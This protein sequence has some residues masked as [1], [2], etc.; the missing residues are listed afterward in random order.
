MKTIFTNIILL[1]LYIT[2]N[3]QTAIKR[4]QIGDQVPD[5]TVTNVVNYQADQVKI[6]DFAGKILILDYWFTGCKPCIASWPKLLDLQAKFADQIQI[7]LVNPM[8]N[9]TAVERFIKNW[10]QRSG[11]AFTLPSVTSD[12]VL[13]R[14]LPPSG[15]PTVVWLDGNGIFKAVTDGI[16]L[17]EDNINAI[18]NNEDIGTKKLVETSSFLDPSMPLY[19]NGNGGSGNTLEW[20]SSISRFDDGIPGYTAL[21]ADSSG[22]YITITHAAIH[23]LIMFAYGQGPYPERAIS[24]YIRLATSRIQYEISNPE[25]VMP[26]VDGFPQTQNIYN[27][28]LLSAQ[29]KTVD[30]LRSM[31]RQDI[32][33]YFDLEL[34]LKRITTEC[35]VLTAE[36]TTLISDFNR[37]RNPRYMTYKPGELVLE[38]VA[39]DD[40]IGYLTEYVGADYNVYPV[41][42]ETGFKGLMDITFDDKEIL[43]DYRKMSEYLYDR[44][45][46]KIEKKPYETEVVIVRDAKSY[47][48]DTKP[49]SEEEE[50]I[51]VREA[52]RSIIQQAYLNQRW[53]EYQQRAIPFVNK[54]LQDDFKELQE[55]AWEFCKAEA[56]TDGESLKQAVAWARRSV[57]LDSTYSP[58]NQG[59]LA[60]LLLKLGDKK[61]GLVAAKKALKTMEIIEETT[62][63]TLYLQKK[64]A[65]IGEK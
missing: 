14:I 38:D 2:V 51:R 11:V 58:R 23:P 1:C 47:R 24:N 48:P 18:L 43:S 44:Y 37:V 26:Y 15:Y 21:S 40:F 35:L 4:L 42:D 57:E 32:E 59:I 12:T 45:K 54:Y 8:E 60:A 49:L 27:Y 30:Q 29:P 6:S 52:E 46:M 5:V 28:Q 3:S 62:D 31:M 55:Y 9:K 39:V 16:D 64:L 56:I 53:K 13:S 63:V 33:R 20:T 36:D 25:R 61:Q 19:V 34:E 41:V 7:L 65:E 10:Q 17:N 50:Y 22:Y